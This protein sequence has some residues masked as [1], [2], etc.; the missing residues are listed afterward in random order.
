MVNDP[1]YSIKKRVYES[2]TEKGVVVCDK[3]MES[4]HDSM[5]RNEQLLMDILARN[6][7][8]EIGKRYDF[9]SINSIDEY[10]KRVPLSTFDDYASYVERMADDGQ[11]NLMFAGEPVY[12]YMSS[13]TTGVSKKIPCSKEG[14]Q[15]SEPYMT[16]QIYGLIYKDLGD[17]WSDG[18]TLAM[19]EV[20]TTLTKSGVGWGCFSGRLIKSL[21]KV[22]RFIFCAPVEAMKPKPGT[23]RIYFYSVFALSEPRLSMFSSTFIPYMIEIMRYIEDNWER[24]AKDIEDGELREDTP[25]EKPEHDELKKYFKASP[26]RAAQIREAFNTESTEHFALRI[27]PNLKCI[28]TAAG[29]EYGSY[30]EK[31]RYYVGS[32]PICYHGYV[33]SEG[34]F[35][36]PYKLDCPDSLL[37]VDGSFYEFVPEDETDLNKTL[38]IDRLE[39][40]KAYEVIVTTLSGLYRYMMK[41]KIMITGRVNDCP[42]IRFMGRTLQQLNLVGEKIP[43]SFVQDMVSRACRERGADLTDFAVFNNLEARPLPRHDFF[44][45][46]RNDTDAEALAAKIEEKLSENDFLA[47]YFEIGKVAHPKVFLVQKGTFFEFMQMR[48]AANGM[49]ATSQMKPIHLIQKPEHVEFI[50]GKT[51]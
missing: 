23:D 49:H 8:T 44:V 27:W 14:L 7:D 42:T 13:A 35:S 10:K 48:A 21:Q 43:I 2:V 22:A 37:L 31:L 45:E 11:K 39:V 51:I 47:N 19:A 32:T 9:A 33:A 50:L 29:G 18:N 34:V 12:Y 25:L 15:F 41:D 6:K 5:K 36:A 30:V 17:I 3:L 40:G 24:L 38:T 20:E 16:S 28:V 1:Y 4:T 26:E 46:L